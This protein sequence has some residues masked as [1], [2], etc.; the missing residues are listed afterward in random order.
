MGLAHR[1]VQMEIEAH[2]D[3][4]GPPISKV[5]IDKDGHV[6]W[7]DKGTCDSSKA[8]GTPRGIIGN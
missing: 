6:H 2:P 5:E 4:T 3:L 8:D 1:F 7:L